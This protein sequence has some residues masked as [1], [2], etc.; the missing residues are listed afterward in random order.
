MLNDL[1]TTEVTEL[2]KRALPILFSVDSRAACAT[3]CGYVDEKRGLWSALLAGGAS[4]TLREEFARQ[5]QQ[6]AKDQ[7]EGRSTA[8]FPTELAVAFGVSAVVEI[9]AYWLQHRA[10]FTLDQVA[11]ILDQLVIAPI[12]RR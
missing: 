2:L 7:P 4:G 1:A 8:R 6:L 9:L 11:D 12:L 5:A 3:L 10:A